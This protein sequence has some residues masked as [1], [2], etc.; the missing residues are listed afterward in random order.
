MSRAAA[1]QEEER[2][3]NSILE[4]LLLYRRLAQEEGFRFL[5]FH[6]P[7]SWEI[8]DERYDARLSRMEAFAAEEGLEFHDLKPDI[9]RLVEE[10]ALGRYYWEGDGHFTEHS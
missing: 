8:A 3:L 7:L 10:G 1:A 2:S 9:A 5:L 6:H 4:L